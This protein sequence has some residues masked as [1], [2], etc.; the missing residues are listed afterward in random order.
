MEILIDRVNPLPDLDIVYKPQ[1][2]SYIVFRPQSFGAEPLKLGEDIG[3]FLD[4]IVSGKIYDE[5]YLD[6]RWDLNSIT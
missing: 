3:Y 5:E 1:E 2:K 6:D 4:G